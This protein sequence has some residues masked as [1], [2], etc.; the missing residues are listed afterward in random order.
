MENSKLITLIKQEVEDLEELYNKHETRKVK[1]GAYN[2]GC[3]QN[4]KLMCRTIRRH[5][6]N[7]INNI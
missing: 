2:T 4:V 5:L 7:V 1:N 6:A 3:K